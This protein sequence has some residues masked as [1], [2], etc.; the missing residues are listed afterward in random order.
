MRAP[1][2]IATVVVLAVGLVAGVVSLFATPSDPPPLEPITVHAP[3]AVDQPPGPAEGWQPPAEPVPRDPAGHVAPPPPVDDD[4]DDDED[5]DPDDG[6]DDDG[7][8][9]D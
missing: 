8:D 2:T 7:P 6:P 9:D 4:E 5:D 3:A 1:L